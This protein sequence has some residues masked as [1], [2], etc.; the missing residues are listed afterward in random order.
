MTTAEFV[1]NIIAL[2]AII[3]SVYGLIRDYRI[4]KRAHEF[5]IFRD[6]YKEFLVKRLPEARSQISITRAGVISG[7]D[8]LIGELTSLRKASIYFQY[9][10]PQFYDNLKKTLWDLEDYLV[11]LPTPFVG[12][13]RANFEFEVN[14]K[15]AAIYRCLLK[16]F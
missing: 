16:K 12:E 6:V 5:D 14:I 10:E 13:P 1:S 11:M 9:A 4:E 8:N 7:V 3:I 15:L 2:I